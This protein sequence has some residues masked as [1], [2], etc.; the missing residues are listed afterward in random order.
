[1]ITNEPQFVAQPIL[2]MFE[3]TNYVSTI[4][5]VKGDKFT[6]NISRF[7]STKENKKASIT[8]VFTKYSHVKSFAFGDSI[9]D[10]G[11]F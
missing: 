10:V 9:G 6:G 1:M 11:M 2:N 3:F 4:F 5:E 8:E 7:N